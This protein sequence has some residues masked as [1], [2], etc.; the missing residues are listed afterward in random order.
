MTHLLKEFAKE[1]QAQT[2]MPDG[3]A[4]RQADAE[5]MGWE[6]AA[7]CCC[8][9][10]PLPACSPA[11]S[12]RAEHALLLGAVL[13][14]HQFPARGQNWPGQSLENHAN[15]RTLELWNKHPLSKSL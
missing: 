6:T 14:G 13:P 11:S 8:P 4:T 1:S 2:P 3:L 9:E 10:G 5:A 12:G 7:L 15:T